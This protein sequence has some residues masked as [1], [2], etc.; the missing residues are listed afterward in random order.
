MQ[1]DRGKKPD[2]PQQPEQEKKEPKEQHSSAFREPKERDQK[3]TINTEEANLEQER[4]EAMTE[5]D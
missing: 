2:Q 4:K 1:N 3:S 5:R